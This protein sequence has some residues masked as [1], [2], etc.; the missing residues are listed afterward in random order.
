MKNIYLLS[1]KVV[2]LCLISNP[3]SADILT[4][5]YS[6]VNDK[7]TSWAETSIKGLRI[8]SRCSVFIDRKYNSDHHPGFLMNYFP[9][10]QLFS[11]F[12]TSFVIY[13]YFPV[14]CSAEPHFIAHISFVRRK[15]P[16]ER[17]FPR[18]IC[19]T[20]SWENVSSIN[21]ILTYISI[22]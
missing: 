1:I 20:H 3:L 4:T 21:R 13:R 7:P 6:S 18:T 10:F 11:I 2:S 9:N 22:L 16:L 14:K 12:A 17:F 15:Y 19:G 5:S 8:Q